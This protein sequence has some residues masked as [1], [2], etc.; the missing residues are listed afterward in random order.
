MFDFVRNHTRLALGF[1][2]LLIVPSFIFF[3]VQGYSKY[4]DATNESVARVDGAAITRAEWED[5]HRRYLDSM[6]QQAPGIDPASLDS[7]ELRRD[8]LDRLVR[9]RV[10]LAAANGLHLYPSPQRMIRLFD[11]EPQFQGLRGPDGKINRDLL[12]AQGL[13]PELFDQRL[14]QDFG[15]RQVLAGISQT[16]PA[17]AAPASAALDAFLQRRE[18]RVLRFEPAAYRAKVA[19]TD[20][21]M[22]AYYKANQAQFKAPEQAEIEYVVLD[23]DTLSKGVSPSD[24][25]LRKFYADNLARYTA[26]EERRASHIL[27]KAEKDAPAAD[28]QKA[29]AKAESLLAEVRKT[30]AAF[31]ELARKNSDDPGSAAKGGDLDFF[32]KGS[33]VK[34]FEDTVFSLKAGEI[35]NVVETD[36]GYHVITLIAVRGGQARP[37]EEVR[38]EIEAELRKSTAQ[39]RWA[40]SAEQ[41]TNTVYEQSDSLK[42]VIDKL[43]LERKSATVQRTATPGTTGPLASPKFLDAVFSNDAINNKRNTDAVEA[44]PNQLVSARIVKHSPAAVPALSEVKDKVRARLVET[45]AAAMAVKE[46]QSRLA[47]LRAGSA[48]D[49][50]DLPAAVIVARTKPEGL[51]KPLMD[52]VLKA[53]ATKLPVT[54]GVDLGPQ[55]YVVLRVTQVLPRE[56]LPGGEESARAQVAQ[57]WANAEAEAYLAALK[58][59]YKAEIKPAAATFADA[60]SSPAR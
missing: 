26:P 58:K 6:R 18:V 38:A 36:F 56:P 23:L 14:R 1:M 51:S 35:S 40:E 33:M 21:E 32:G 24:A 8:T 43:K 52:A 42:P 41:F 45:Q 25:D 54:E 7:A 19:P 11:S 57:A 13:S 16:A 59:R 47:A 53:D 12:A 3:G 48:A 49:L 5:A 10:L 34:P 46:G 30:P 20:A 27:I 29:K 37:F 17:P 60:A 15:V 55:G 31:A 39:K 44:G 4:T 22:E 2:L 28:R 9:E 50:A